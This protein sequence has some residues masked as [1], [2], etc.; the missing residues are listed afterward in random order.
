MSPST[1]A[2]T[3][4]CPIAAIVPASR[5]LPVTSAIRTPVDPLPVTV[6]WP[7][8]VKAP[9]SGPPSQM[10]A[11]LLPFTVIAPLLTIAPV[12]APAVRMPVR[13]VP[14][15]NGPSRS[16]SLSVSVAT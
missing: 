6:V 2:A 14:A 12:Y 5:T 16:P 10:P 7:S 3:A 4:P 13:P 8:C 15:A 9:V 11:E 1:R